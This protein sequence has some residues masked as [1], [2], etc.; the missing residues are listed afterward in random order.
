[1]E[2]PNKADSENDIILETQHVWNYEEF[3]HTDDSV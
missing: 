3:S 1:M 2:T